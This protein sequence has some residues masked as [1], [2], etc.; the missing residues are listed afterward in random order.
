MRNSVPKTKMV[1]P[2]ECHPRLTPTS[3]CT[4][5]HMH[6]HTHPYMNLHMCIYKFYATMLVFGYRDSEL[7]DLGSTVDVL[8]ERGILQS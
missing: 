6:M 5:T 2:V 3:T 1:A 8:T 7:V 4:H